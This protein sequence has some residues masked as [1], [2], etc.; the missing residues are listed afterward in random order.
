MYNTCFVYRFDNFIFF[1]GLLGVLFWWSIM[2]S[3][4]W[5]SSPST[6]P[7]LLLFFYRL[8][9]L[10]SLDLPPQCMDNPYFHNFTPCHHHRQSL[11]LLAISHGV[12]LRLSL[13]LS[14][15]PSIV[16]DTCFESLLF[17]SD[18]FWTSR[19][20]SQTC[21]TSS[22]SYNVSVAYVLLSVD[23][24]SK[25]RETQVWFDDGNHS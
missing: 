3:L 6:P 22:P 7:L 17:H 20:I 25:L 24:P 9:W 4:S 15:M 14:V 23:H 5:C 12:W 18:L 2:C 11:A 16:S 13:Y 1:R 10:L 19:G 8:L 21:L